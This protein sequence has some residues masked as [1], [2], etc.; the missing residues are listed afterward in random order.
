V[1]AGAAALYTVFD[2]AVMT[3]VPSGWH[4]MLALP[5]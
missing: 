2:V 5:R 4:S 1:V 3:A